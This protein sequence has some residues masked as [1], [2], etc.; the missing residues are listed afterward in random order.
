M[1]KY[2]S[3]KISFIEYF[4]N[5][6]REYIVA[7]LRSKIYPNERDQIYYREREMMGKRCKIESISA[8]NNFQNIFNSPYIRN[9]FYDEIY[10]KT[11]LPNF[12]YRDDS[13]RQK[14]GI[15]DI[16]HY[17]AKNTPVTVLYNDCCLRGRVEG[18]DIQQKLIIVY[19]FDLENKI[20][21][22]FDRVARYDLL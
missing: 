17:F 15:L 21:V 5:L 8:V 18:V 2:K 9:K 11:G 19:V 16:Y 14:R 1:K 4:E 13:D 10:N 12:I 20:F 6:Q 3:R 22:D 7:E